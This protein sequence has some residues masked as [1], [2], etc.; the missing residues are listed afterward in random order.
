MPL[1]RSAFLLLHVL[2]RESALCP[3]PIVKI[4]IYYCLMHKNKHPNFI[5]KDLLSFEDA[6]FFNFTRI[7]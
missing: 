4:V 7:N 5:H 2:S 6:P 1:M 3:N